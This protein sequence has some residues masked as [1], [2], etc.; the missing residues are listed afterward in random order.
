MSKPMVI[1]WR[2]LRQERC[3]CAANKR[4]AVSNA[5]A[6]LP[7][8]PPTRPLYLLLKRCAEVAT[9]RSLCSAAALLSCCC[10]HTVHTARAQISPSVDLQL[11]A[12]ALTLETAICN[13][14]RVHTW[15]AVAQNTLGW[16][17]A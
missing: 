9:P 8:R 11:R 2:R 12:S 16:V 4:A 1:H 7:Y 10:S 15:W 17:N 14:A 3:A 13:K 5:F 6:N